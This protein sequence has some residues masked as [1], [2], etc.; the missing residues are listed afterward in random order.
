[1]LLL[2]IQDKNSQLSDIQ[3]LRAK[4][5]MWF[6]ELFNWLKATIFWDIHSPIRNTSRV[7]PHHGKTTY[8]WNWSFRAGGAQARTG[9]NIKLWTRTKGLWHTTHFCSTADRPYASIPWSYPV[10]KLMKSFKVSSYWV[11]TLQPC[12]IYRTLGFTHHSYT[13]EDE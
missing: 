5:L 10:T 12:N 3:N 1:M 7:R 11:E 13:E 8:K 4:S 6:T 2:S 9:T